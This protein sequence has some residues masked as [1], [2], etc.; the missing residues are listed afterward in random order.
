MY[1]QE[2]RKIKF[3]LTDEYQKAFYDIKELLITP[4]VLTMP[5]ANKKFWLEGDTSKTEAGTTSF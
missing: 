3:R 1:E 4:P 5:T 2:R